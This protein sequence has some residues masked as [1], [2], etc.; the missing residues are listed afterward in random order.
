MFLEDNV[1]GKR[2]LSAF[3]VVSYLISWHVQRWAVFLSLAGTAGDKIFKE[4]GDK[5]RFGFGPIDCPGW[6]VENGWG[7][8]RGRAGL[9][10]LTKS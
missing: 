7:E 10:M 9:R 1:K 6:G 3:Q 4:D 2:P 5:I 8:G